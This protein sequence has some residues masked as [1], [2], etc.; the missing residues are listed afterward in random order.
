MQ[1]VALC[2]QV[3]GIQSLET[4]DTCPSDDYMSRNFSPSGGTGND[5][6]KCAVNRQTI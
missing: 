6:Y 1:Y 3:A 4:F 5:I 2:L